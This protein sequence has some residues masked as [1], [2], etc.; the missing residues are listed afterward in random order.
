MCRSAAGTKDQPGR[1]VKQK[2]GLNRSILDQAWGEFRRQLEYKQAWSG[3]R[4]LAVPP[5]RTSQTCPGCVHVS[6]SNRKTQAV[7][8]CMNCGYTSKCGRRCV[9]QHRKGGARPDRLPSERCSNAVSS[10][11]PTNGGAMRNH[12]AISGLQAGEDVNGSP[13]S[14]L[15]LRRYSPHLHRAFVFKA[16]FRTAAF[17]WQAP[18]SGIR[19]SRRG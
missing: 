9:Y 2:S 7:F 12:V 16:P 14:C 8:L 1:N 6:R 18:F 10:R 5:G 3:G 15:L 19:R 13:R 11:N 17:L 4:V